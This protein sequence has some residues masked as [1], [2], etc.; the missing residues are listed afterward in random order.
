MFIF[1]F[2]FLFLQN[3]RIVIDKY[4]GILDNPNST[5][6]SVG[7]LHPLA[8]HLEQKNASSGHT[9]AVYEVEGNHTSTQVAGLHMLDSE[10]DSDET[11]KG[12]D[13]RISSTGRNLFS[14]GC[15]IRNSSKT[16]N[17][18]QIKF[19]IFFS[20]SCQ[21]LNQCCCECCIVTCLISFNLC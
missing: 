2:S 15:W 1:I 17:G 20:L 8:F 21:Y 12:V 4:K 14:I 19:S 16:S 5:I 10:F 7:V 3:A 13:F 11:N 9:P 18:T 6:A